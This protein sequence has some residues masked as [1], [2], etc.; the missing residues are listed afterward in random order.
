MGRS[1]GQEEIVVKKMGN[2]RNLSLKEDKRDSEQK[3]V[4]FAFDFVKK[5]KIG[6]MS[7]SGSCSVGFVFGSVFL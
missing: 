3:S 4:G 6:H 5:G 2:F 1:N 7:M